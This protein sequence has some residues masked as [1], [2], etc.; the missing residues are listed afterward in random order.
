MRSCTSTID[1]RCSRSNWHTNSR[2]KRPPRSVSSSKKVYKVF[3]VV[4]Y[5]H[6]KKRLH[7][8]RSVHS[9]STVTEALQFSGNFCK[10]KRY[11]F[12]IIRVI[13]LLEPGQRSIYTRQDILNFDRYNATLRD[14]AL[15]LG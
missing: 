12:Y 4:V 13:V 2:G 15:A 10:K 11:R 1:L 3:L 6:K 8:H 5:F 14:G 7:L 9:S